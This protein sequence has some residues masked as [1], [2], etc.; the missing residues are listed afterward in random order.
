MFCCIILYAQQSISYIIKDSSCLF[1]FDFLTLSH[2]YA[3]TLLQLYEL[4]WM[5]GDD[6]MEKAFTWRFGFDVLRISQILLMFVKNKATVN[7]SW[8]C[9]WYSF[10]VLIGMIGTA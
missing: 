4:R 10:V 5:G 1:V 7:V 9:L 3:E 8:V 2:P 6:I